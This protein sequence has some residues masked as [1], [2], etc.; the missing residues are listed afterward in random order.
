MNSW[1]MN[2]LVL[3]M[4]GATMKFIFE[5]CLVLLMHGAIMKSIFELCFP[6]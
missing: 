2:Y 4:H 6:L 1:T 3:L 5:L